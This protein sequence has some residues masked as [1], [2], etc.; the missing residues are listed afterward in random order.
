MRSSRLQES[1]HPVRKSLENLGESFTPDQPSLFE[2]VEPPSPGSLNDDG[3][4]REI[5]TA[6]I[7]NNTKSRQQ[8][9]E[10]MSRLTGAAVTARMLNS[11]TSEA[12][13]QHRWPAQYTRAFCYV[14]KDWT[15]LRCIVERSGFYMI[16]PAEEELLELGREY[17]KQKR[18]SEQIQAI[19]KRLRGVD[20]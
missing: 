9:A 15:L 12:A 11:Y 10:E 19:E 17:L 3:L 13:E 16:T 6:A 4:V 7:R 20:L 5:V 8:I 1:S 2:R 14:V 18:A